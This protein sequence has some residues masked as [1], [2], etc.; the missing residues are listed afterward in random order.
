M[1]WSLGFV[2]T[3]RCWSGALPASVQ[4][5]PSCALPPLV[6]GL[7]PSPDCQLPEG[8]G[9]V[10]PCFLGTVETLW[11]VCWG[12]EGRHCS[13]CHSGCYSHSWAVNQKDKITLNSWRD[14]CTLC[15]NHRFKHIE[16]FDVHT[17][18]P[19]ISKID[20]WSKQLKNLN[21]NIM[22]SSKFVGLLESLEFL[23]W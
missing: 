7:F 14:E 11:K 10:L 5:F 1:P 15:L 3:P 22:C 20:T 9:H 17:L 16:E 19:E 23:A 2:L 18:L 6:T 12:K 21:R 13:S 4:G 8:R